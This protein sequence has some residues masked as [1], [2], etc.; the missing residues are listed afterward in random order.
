MD[1]RRLWLQ[2]GLIEA[3]ARA[4]AA[5]RDGTAAGIRAMAMAAGRAMA[6]AGIRQTL[7]LLPDLG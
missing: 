6:A 1:L 4:R 7:E 2:L 5:T 3:A